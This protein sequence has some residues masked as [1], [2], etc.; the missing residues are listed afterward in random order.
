MKLVSFACCII[1]IVI[2]TI[3]AQSDL[4]N[5][6]ILGITQDGGYPHLGCKKECCARVWKDES[7]R[8][9]VVSLALVDP[10][11][12]KWWLFEATPDIREQLQLFQK[13]T[14]GEYSYLP[15]G[16]FITHAH[17]GHY[18]GLMQL[19][20]EVM[21]TK[22]V[23]V[24]VMPRMKKFLETNGPWS[25]LVQLNNIL[26]GELKDG[27]KM[28]L[29]DGY[30]VQA[31]NVPHRD[32]YSET[33]GF[34]IH[35]KSKS[36]LFIPDIDKWSK[37]N[38]NIIAEVKTVDY[39]FLDAT[40]S[41]TDELKN[42]AIEEIPHPLVSETLALFEQETSQIKSKIVF[43]HFNHS[44]PLMWSKEEMKNVNK[45]GFQIAEQGKSY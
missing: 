15:D 7:K 1:L 40:F 20:R 35:T 14:H 29:T 2:R 10:N 27:A 19:G 21:N 43:I 17:I 22:D 23:P 9:F 26:P 34:K 5:I 37:W 8:K 4:S 11:E 6:F 30:W 3:S 12:K 16:I 38:K 24:Y 18:S 28:F 45:L 36:Y 39:A 31:F 33:A 32:E 25:Q 13:L 41:K 44:N 42:R